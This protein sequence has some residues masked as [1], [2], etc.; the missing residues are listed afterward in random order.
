MIIVWKGK[1]GGG[2]TR[3]KKVSEKSQRGGIIGTY[4]EDKKAS[5]KTV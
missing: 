4:T 2:K 3:G 5:G 1:R